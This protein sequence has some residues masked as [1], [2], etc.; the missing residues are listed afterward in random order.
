MDLRVVHYNVTSALIVEDDVDWDVRIQSL[1]EA[2]AKASTAL[3]EDPSATIDFRNVPVRTAN[4][5]SP[6]GAEWDLLWLGHCGMSL[7]NGGQNHGRV[8]QYDDPSVPE[9]HYLKSY[10]EHAPTP[11]TIY[12]SHTRVVTFETG[13]VCSLAYAV[14]QSGARKLLHNLGLRAL[15]APFDVMLRSFCDGTDGNEIN[16][17]LS[18]IPQLFDHH[19]RAGSK[20]GDSDINDEDGFR[21]TAW[22][23]NIRWSVRM[24]MKK[25]LR[26]ETD[27][28][29]Q[30]PDTV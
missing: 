8:I 21:D 7:P 17:C 1:F 2:F 19:R 9:P 28:D 25:L 14:S 12:P 10:L 11:L 18:V 4:Q 15:N 26:G 5:S 30:Y 27:F 3:L 16:T 22:T 23:N 29:D 6:F 13:A 24:N 20:K